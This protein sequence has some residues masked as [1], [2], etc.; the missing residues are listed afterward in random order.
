MDKKYPGTK[1]FAFFGPLLPID[2]KYAIGNFMHSAINKTTINLKSSGLSERS[3]LHSSDLAS[4]IIY[5]LSNPIIGPSHIGSS[6]HRP[7][8][9]WAEFISHVFDCGPVVTGDFNEQ[10]SFYVPEADDRIPNLSS[11]FVRMELLFKNWFDWLK[12]TI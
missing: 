1:L 6:M 5:L 11:S 7:L 12:T 10:H 3:Y 4:Q 9:E 8:L 2:Q